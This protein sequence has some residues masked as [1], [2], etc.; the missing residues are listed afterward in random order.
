MKKNLQFSFYLF[1]LITTQTILA[2]QDQQLVVLIPS[3]NN[4][5]FYEKN[6][7][8][9]LSQKTD[10]FDFEILYVDDCSPDGTAGLVEEFTKT[11]NL[12]GKISLIKNPIRCR[13]M[14]NIY[15]AIHRYCDDK[16]IVAVY[17]GDDWLLGDNAFTIITNAYKN[18]NTWMTYGS[19]TSTVHGPIQWCR[20]IPM[21][22]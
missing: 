14:R 5:A 10:T 1:C 20:S 11:N 6:L 4:S 12:Q 22:S 9:V 17:D 13:A 3:Y 18:P 2:L 21:T 7:N 15:M 16:K 19:L 8:T